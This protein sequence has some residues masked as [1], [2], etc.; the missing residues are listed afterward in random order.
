MYTN[1]PT[2]GEWSKTCRYC[3][4]QVTMA[5]PGSTPLCVAIFIQR[6][7]YDN[8]RFNLVKSA[9]R[10]RLHIPYAAPLERIMEQ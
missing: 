8:T 5:A 6:H 10:Y 4:G 7:M 1:Q 2:L 9:N 3:E